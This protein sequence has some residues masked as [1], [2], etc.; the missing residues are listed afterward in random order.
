MDNERRPASDDALEA[1][2]A[3]V[4]TPPAR[5]QKNFFERNMIPLKGDSR[6]TKRRKVIFDSCLVVIFVCLLV[7]AWVVVIDPMQS[8]KLFGDLANMTE[9]VVTVPPTE[10]P[11]PSDGAPP[12]EPVTKP[13]YEVV[14]MSHEQLKARNGDYRGWLR[15]PGADIS[16]PI[17]QTADNGYYLKRDYDRKP[18]K[19][20]NPFVDYRCNFNPM[21]T[22]LVIYGHHMSNGTIFTYLPR[23]KQANVV[24][25]NPIITLELPDGTVK[26]YKILSVLAINGREQD[27]KSR[28]AD[29]GGYAFAANTPEFPNAESFNG[30]IR[31]I[32][33]R[34][35]V[36]TGVDVEYG[37][38]LI[39]LQTCVYDFDY[40]FLYVIG[41]LVRPNESA[42]VSGVKANTNPRMPQAWYD[43]QKKP[44]PYADAERWSAP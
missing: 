3:V 40:E 10:A 15:A 38:K 28:G 27:D 22:N 20:G 35:Y 29:D 12:T 32:K 14:R 7:L 39:S 21:S 23:Y 8:K 6:K 19:Y 1:L 16:L 31:Q 43:K 25:N 13:K 41:R 34:S 26:K 5:R 11:P 18:S 4:N 33:Q 24:K 9:T 36:D 17:V 44:N 37:D 2:D 30:Y 42:S